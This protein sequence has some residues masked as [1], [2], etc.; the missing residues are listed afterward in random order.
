VGFIEM[1][2]TFLLFLLI[3]ALLTFILR[4]LGIDMWKILAG[5]L[6]SLGI[7]SLVSGFVASF[8]SWVTHSIGWILANLHLNFL[9]IT[10]LFFIKKIF[11]YIIYFWGRS[12]KKVRDFLDRMEVRIFVILEQSKN[13]RGKSI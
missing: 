10:P 4:F 7:L 3:L 1:N 5:M 9:I 11:V 12:S 6:L 8:L 13:K 2:L